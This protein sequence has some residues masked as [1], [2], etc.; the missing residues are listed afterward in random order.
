MIRRTMSH[1][2]TLFDTAIG[3][4]GIAWS[5]RGIVAFQLPEAS[6]GQTRAR[7][8]RGL[9]EPREQDPPPEVRQAIDGVIALLKGEKRDLAEIRLDMTGV[10]PFH[11]QVYQVT[12][13]IPPG[14]TLSY[15]EIALRLGTPGAARAVGQALGRNPFAVIVP[16]HRVLSAGGKLHGF[17]AAG[18]IATKR[19]LLA[20]EGAD[21]AEQRSLFDGDI[22]S[23]AR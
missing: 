4:C 13:A 17:S 15:G 7:L 6:D 9:A 21:L 11:R 3:R 18:G 5:D 22:G 12:R 14:A 20:I 1:D 10:P 2:F 23:E 19:R 8:V 16:C